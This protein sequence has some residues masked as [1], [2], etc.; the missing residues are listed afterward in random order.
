MVGWKACCLWTRFGSSFSFG[1]KKPLAL[2]P[3]MLDFYFRFVKWK[4]Y[5]QVNKIVRNYLLLLLNVV[6]FKYTTL[7]ICK[8]AFKTTSKNNQQYPLKAKP[9]AY[10]LYVWVPDPIPDSCVHTPFGILFQTF[11]PFRQYSFVFMDFSVSQS[12]S[13]ISCNS[14]SESIFLFCSPRS[15]Q[16]SNRPFSICQVLPR[17]TLLL[18]LFVFLYI[19]Y[20]M[21]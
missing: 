9:S 13:I 19:S 2:V 12:E 21:Y 7:F 11:S 10:S 1:G 17:Y 18:Y 5:Q 14:Q 16:N 15:I 3:S 8:T 6:N 4:V 20:I